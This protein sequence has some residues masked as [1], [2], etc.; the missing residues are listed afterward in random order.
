MISFCKC[1][2]FIF[3][4]ITFCPLE[5]NLRQLLSSTIFFGRLKFVEFDVSWKNTI[6]VDAC[7]KYPFSEKPRNF[8]FQNL[9]V[10]NI[11]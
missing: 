3:A 5:K 4:A 7:L 8:Y 6:A 10:D 11:F 2:K 1:A 9:R